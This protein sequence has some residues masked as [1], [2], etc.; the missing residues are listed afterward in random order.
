M[1]VNTPLSYRNM[2]LYSVFVRDHGKNG[3]FRDVEED[4]GRIRSLGTD[5]I[6]LMPVHPIGE[7]CRKGSVGS[8]YAIRDYRAVNPDMGTMDDFIRLT[9][10]IRSHGMKCIIDVVYNHTSPDSVLAAEHPEWFRRDAQDR[11]CAKVP[12]WYD[13]VDLDYSVPELWDYQIETLKYWAQYVDGFRCDVA[14]VVP[15]SFW[16]RAREEVEK[17]R[18]GAL[19]LAET[20]E[21]E[22]IRL[23]RA[24]GGSCHSDA[25]IF[26]AFDISYDYDILDACENYLKG[27]GPLQTWLDGLNRQEVLYP[28]N[29]VKLHFLENHDRERFCS[30][31]SDPVLRKQ[32]LAF[33]FFQ[34]GMAFLYGGQERSA[35]HRP[36]LFETEPVD[37]SGEDLSDTIR[38][39]MRIKRLT[40]LSEGSF[41]AE[42][43]CEGIVFAEY[44]LGSERLAGFFRLGGTQAA[45]DGPDPEAFR[46]QTSLP[47]GVYRN[48]Y[49][50]AAVEVM[51]GCLTLAQDPVILFC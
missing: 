43:L 26:Q 7:K 37:W 30:Y 3:T 35:V 22:F 13:I 1:A 39:M 40:I 42:K 24:E 8:P 12:D 25:E 38:A 31:T 18:P 6:W 46:V 29:Y 14:P 16:L 34:K 49:N 33:S 20:V 15:L 21:P 9:D 41:F 48:E 23:I 28:L 10:A 5:V 17:V 51:E 44:R 50:G 4:L 32:Q 19:W 27:S 45:A 47:D 2:L 11:P 36:S